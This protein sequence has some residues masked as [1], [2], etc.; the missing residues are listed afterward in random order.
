VVVTIVITIRTPR[1]DYPAY[2]ELANSFPTS[3]T[4]PK[5]HQHLK[6]KHKQQ[7]QPHNNLSLPYLPITLHPTTTQQHNNKHQHLKHR[8][9]HLKYITQTF[10]RTCLSLFYFS[11][12]SFFPLSFL[13][14]F[15]F[16]KFTENIILPPTKLP[17]LLPILDYAEKYYNDN[18]YLEP[19]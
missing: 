7:P 19:K 10:Q 18:K 17:L 13:S 14:Y 2:T 6:H 9:R 3:S 1:T 11:A 16:T 15:K 5:Q 12:Q 4:W 8:H